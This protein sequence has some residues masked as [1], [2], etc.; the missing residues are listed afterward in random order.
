MAPTGIW[1]V[2]AVAFG[3]AAATAASWESSAT[4]RAGLGDADMAKA[5]G[6]IRTRRNGAAATTRRG[7][8]A[9]AEAAGRAASP[10]PP[11]V[12][13]PR[14]ESHAIHEPKGQ[15][16]GMKHRGKSKGHEG[17]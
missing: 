16:R 1:S 3:S 4:V 8:G 7:E 15:Q 6:R 9:L 14:G 13:A 5:A 2:S 12:A 11:W 17:V 10:A